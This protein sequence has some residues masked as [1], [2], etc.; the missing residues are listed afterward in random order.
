[1]NLALWLLV[2]VGVM[3]VAELT[4]SLYMTHRYGLTEIHGLAEFGLASV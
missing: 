3:L 1:M 4:P 2:L